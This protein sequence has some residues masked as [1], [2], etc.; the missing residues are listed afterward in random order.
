MKNR[1][2]LCRGYY[3]V[4]LYLDE[5]F[6]FCQMPRPLCPPFN[7][8]IPNYVETSWLPWSD[9]SNSCGTGIR[10]RYKKCWVKGGSCDRS[11]KEVEECES[12]EGCELPIWGSWSSCSVTCGFGIRQRFNIRNGSEPNRKQV[13][14]CE[15]GNCDIGQTNVTNW[16][17]W[18]PC[19]L[20]SRGYSIRTRFRSC[21]L[22]DWDWE[23][24]VPLEEIESC[25]EFSWGPWSSCSVSCGDVGYRTRTGSCIFPPGCN[26][27][28]I[29]EEKCQGLKPCPIFSTWTDFS[30]CSSDCGPGTQ[31]RTRFCIENCD[32]V[33]PKNLTETIPCYTKNGSPKTIFDSDCKPF[34]Y[35]YRVV[36]ILCLKPDGSE[37][38]CGKS[39]VPTVEKRE[40][41]YDGFCKYCKLNPYK[42][43]CTSI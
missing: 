28:K 4:G 27:I 6:A 10:S 39:F 30:P 41:C 2:R 43:F 37:G 14:E 40:R 19:H 8:F 35:C 3:G 26:S 32:T 15:V 24:N 25:E 22:N 9:C 7:K 21:I 12:Y 38:C 29:E 23:C 31:T 36:S 1:T 33:S 42:R 20:D 34:P 5:D 13:E 11:L 17:P 18:S 16:Y